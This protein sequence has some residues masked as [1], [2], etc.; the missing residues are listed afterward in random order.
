MA[1]PLSI[2]GLATGVVSLDIQL[3]HDL[4]TFLDIVKHRDEDIAKLTRQAATMAQALDAIDRSLQNRSQAN[5]GVVDSQKASSVV[6]FAKV[7]TQ[8]LKYPRQRANIQKLEEGLDQA[9][10]TLQLALNAFGLSELSSIKSNTEVVVHGLSNVQKTLPDVEARVSELSQELMAT[11]QTA[12][13][14][15]QNIEGILNLS[16]SSHQAGL[17]QLGQAQSNEFSQIKRLIQDL[18]LKMDANASIGPKVATASFCP[19]GH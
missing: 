1:D 14:S 16:I 17:E 8:K 10:T 7:T 12:T 2:A 13:Q 15:I 18:S 19:T 6:E 9:N 3:Y 5:N 4:Q 11:N